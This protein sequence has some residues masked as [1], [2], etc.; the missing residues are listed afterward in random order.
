MLTLVILF[1]AQLSPANEESVHAD[2]SCGYEFRYSAEWLAVADVQESR[3]CT[4]TI[5]PKDYKKRMAERDVD[6]YTLILQ[7]SE[8]SFLT[9]AEEAGFDFYDGS[10]VTVGRQGARDTAEL[11]KTANL[12]GL[13]G[14]ITS[15]CHHE[16]GGYAGL[17]S[18]EVFVLRDEEDRNLILHAKPEAKSAIPLI[19]KTFKFFPR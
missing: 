9:A 1:L 2:S 7:V 17:C 10:W 5:R 15:G 13:H 6:V 3:K 18:I 11:Y 12:S 8:G 19:L 16:K 4:V 14:E